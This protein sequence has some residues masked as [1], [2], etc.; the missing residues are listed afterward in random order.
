MGEE[1]EK[2]TTTNKQ[3]NSKTQR[4]PKAS[5]R[6]LSMLLVFA[7]IIVATAALMGQL[8]L[9]KARL[10][11]DNRQ[12][13]SARSWLSMARCWPRSAEWFYLSAILDRRDDDFVGVEQNLK[14]AHE[15]GYNVSDLEHQQMLAH[16]QTGQ[17]Q[18][19]GNRWAELFR[20]AGSDGPEVCDAFVKYALAR[21]RLDEAAMVIETWKAD[22]PNDPR[23]Y[24]VE[25]NIT[26]VLQRWPDAERLYRQALKID[27]G[28]TD[29]RIQL[30]E[31]LI[32][33]LKFA[34][35]EKQLRAV[36]TDASG[37]P[38]AQAALAH[39]VAQQGR[40][41]EARQL[42]SA[43]LENSPENLRLLAESGRL[44]LMTND[45]EQ[46]VGALATVLEK[47]PEN[48]ELRYSYAQ[49]LRNLGRKDEAR[50][51][52][53]LVDD[54]TKALLQLARLTNEVVADPANVET[55]FKVAEITWRWKS[56]SDGAAWLH[57]VL[58][59]D[60]DHRETHALLATHYAAIGDNEKAARH[61][62]MSEG[63][64]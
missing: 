48:T 21:F 38:A 49:A 24:L 41:N 56:R 4:N 10:A 42:L 23:P 33:Q 18:K 15:L 47:E 17:F 40:T 57:S 14:R 1:T 27:P 11:I 36:V 12:H 63:P 6:R 43:A 22:F 32:K 59:F 44:F 61:R 7:V 26:S 64:E 55:R 19:V 50:E 31:A 25:G 20:T 9:W 34:A 8:G 28:L 62:Q 29:A 5:R 45:N 35:A 60:P 2:L 37:T 58:E 46:A 3:R 39:A 51:H 16:A 53:Q 54:G 52:F 13:H 30:A